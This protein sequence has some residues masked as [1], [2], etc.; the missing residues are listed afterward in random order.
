MLTHCGSHF[1]IYIIQTVMLYA[2]NLYSDVCQL[3]LNKN[4]GKTGKKEGEKSLFC[5]I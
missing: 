4:G 1:T 5:V 2:L 3:F